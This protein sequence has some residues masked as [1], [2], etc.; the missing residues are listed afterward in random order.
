MTIEG[1]CHCGAVRIAVPRAPDWVGSCNCS[2][3]RRTG[4]LV[5]YY[6]PDEVRVEGE[7][8]TYV[9]GDR[10]IRFHHCPTC[11]CHTH[12]DA[13]AEALAGDLPNGVRDALTTRM[14]INARLLDG[15][16]VREGVSGPVAVFEGA[17]LDVRFFDNADG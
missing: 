12:W 4:A 5:A 8:A 15:F 3:C 16:E 14:G 6:R 9:T 7:T 10:F 13:N 1:S 11:A 2:I 17:E